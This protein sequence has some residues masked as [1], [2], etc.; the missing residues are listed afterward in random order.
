MEFPRIQSQIVRVKA[1]IRELESQLGGSDKIAISTYRDEAANIQR[2]IELLS[3]QFQINWVQI[4]EVGEAVAELESQIQETL[5]ELESLGQHGA[6]IQDEIMKLNERKRELERTIAAAALNIRNAQSKV[7]ELQAAVEAGHVQLEALLEEAK[8]TGFE[9]MR[10][11]RSVAA[12]EDE[13]L[14]LQEIIHKNTSLAL[15]YD[16]VAE[17]LRHAQEELQ[18]SRQYYNI[19]HELWTSF[20]EALQRRRSDWEQFRDQ[21]ASAS[22]ESF[23][24]SLELRGF[25]GS[26]EY[27]HDARHLYI[28]VQ[29][30]NFDGDGGS[31]DDEYEAVLNTGKR[32]DI[33][34]LSGGEKSFGT[35]CFLLSLWHAMGCPFR[36]LDE[37]DVF[38]VRS[39]KSKEGLF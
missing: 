22:N 13:I 24:N 17:D 19:N 39:F 35:T 4:Q 23:M 33:K 21:I 2:Q 25:R 5:S 32:R 6:E 37:F 34:Q 27:D 8:E 28:N 26:L 15:N 38:M 20:K 16:D 7:D 10:V 14:K 1:E 29:V 18:R 36:C 31:R 9:R 30:D 3:N 11:R 12:I